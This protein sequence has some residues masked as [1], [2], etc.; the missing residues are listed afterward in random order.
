MRKAIIL[1]EGYFGTT[2]GKTAHGLVRYSRKYEILGVIDSTLAGR[3]AGEV[4]DGVKRGI[5]IYSSLDEALAS[6][7]DADTLIIGVATPGGF[8]PKEYKDIVKRAI[9][10][11]MNIV[12][13]LHEFLSDDPE[14]SSLAR[15]RNVEIVDV[16]KIF[17]DMKIF[18]T[19]KIDEV[20]SLR[21]AVLGTDSAIGKRTTAIKL[22]EELNKSGLRAVFVGT[23]QTAWMQDGRYGVVIDAMINDFVAGG[24]EHEIWRAY[25]EESPDVIVIPGQGSILHPAFPGSFELLA[26]G[27]PHAIVL[28]H[29]PGRKYLDGFPGYPLPDLDRMIKVIE[30][31]TER[32][33]I[34]ITINHENLT[35]EQV[36]RFIKEYESRYGVVAC[37]PIWHGV[38]KIVERIKEEFPEIGSKVVARAK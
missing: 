29:A 17:R 1:A 13:G 9:M 6:C 7:P 28:Q 38:G 35:R 10:R 16:R 14:L 2:D 37:D 25:K 27:K 3:D 5:M 19:G 33:V 15:E 12:S 36:E 20:K 18:Y 32:K 24:I 11:G 22:V 30:L 21:I 23:G 4:L 34:A 31:L 26:A 8:L